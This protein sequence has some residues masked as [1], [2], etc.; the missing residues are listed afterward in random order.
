MEFA[1]GTKSWYINNKL[2]R[3]DGPAL[4]YK[5]G[6]KEWYV[7]GLRHRVDGPAIESSNGER[8]WYLKGRLNREN[9]PAI[10]HMYGT[11]TKEWWLDGLRHRIDGPDCT[12]KEAPA[13]LPGD[14]NGN[15][16]YSFVGI[17]IPSTV[18]KDRTS[19]GHQY[20]YNC[21]NYYILGDIKRPFVYLNNYP[22]KKPII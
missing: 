1:G 12:Y 14:W 6:T 20:T 4:E 21:G 16:E 8:L 18:E 3:E 13:V 17:I 5:N 7:N 19:N 11:E 15:K 22:N 9:G 10:E 2:H